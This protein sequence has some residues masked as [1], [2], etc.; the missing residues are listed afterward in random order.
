MK[1]KT[2]KKKKSE[3]RLSERVR[4][5]TWENKQYEITGLAVMHH[6]AAATLAAFI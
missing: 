5:R 3:E 4:E 2:G 6:S 1:G